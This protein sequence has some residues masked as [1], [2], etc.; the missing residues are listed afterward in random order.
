MAVSDPTIVEEVDPAVDPDALGGPPPRLPATVGALALIGGI[1]VV[2]IVLSVLTDLHNGLRIIAVLAGI[3]V[4]YKGIDALARAWRGPH[5]D[6]T[7]AL[8][9]AWLGLLT[10][11]ALIADLLPFPEHDDPTAA[12]REPTN[13]SPDLFS[14]HPLGTNSLGLDILARAIHGARVSLLTSGLTVAII[15]VVGGLIGLAAGYY[16]GRTDAI[17]SVATDTLLS[18]P[19]L[20][21]LVAFATVLGRPS[22][23]TGAIVKMSIGLAIVGLPT[24]IRLAR[25][26]TLAFAQREFVLAARGIGA[27]HRRVVL[28]ELMPNVAIPL[29]SYA[30][31]VTALFILAE[32]SLSFLG[33][34]LSQPEPTWGNMIAEGQEARVLRTHPHI[35]L[36][37]GAFMFLTIYA[38]NRVGEHFRGA[39]LD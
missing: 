22:T 30:A 4:A 7:Y 19:A 36:V 10:F 34:G 9:C 1:A 5:F 17:V 38:F 3:A 8:S 35:A 25:A 21:L 27:T 32:G 13:L 6:T 15:L 29:L 11:L 39:R 20:V 23:V 14:E 24:M 2:W 26:N 16:R 28:S 37:P 31:I 33:L 12:I 18:I